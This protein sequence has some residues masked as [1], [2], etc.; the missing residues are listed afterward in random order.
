MDFAVSR[1]IEWYGETSSV[2]SVYFLASLV[3][4]FGEAEKIIYNEK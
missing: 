2:G 1:L 3:R 4:I